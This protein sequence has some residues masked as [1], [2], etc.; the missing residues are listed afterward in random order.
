MRLSRVRQCMD[1]IL[2]LTQPGQLHSPWNGLLGPSYMI[3]SYINQ[4]KML[5][6]SQNAYPL[7]LTFISKN[8]PLDLYFPITGNGYFTSIAIL[9]IQLNRALKDKTFDVLH[10]GIW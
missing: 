7:V 3:D 6:T 8:A 9:Y 5:I 4:F 2:C 10:K 1:T